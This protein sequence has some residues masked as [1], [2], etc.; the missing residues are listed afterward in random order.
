MR[1]ILFILVAVLLAGC[2]KPSPEPRTIRV[3]VIGGMVMSGMWAE[4]AAQF[5]H[6]TGL[7]LDVVATGPKEVIGP[8]FREGTA[9]VLTMHSSDVATELVA[10]G[11][12]RNLR[13]WARNELVILAPPGDPAGI[14]GWQDGAAALRR[15]AETQSRFIDAK[16]AGKRI[17]AE[18]L[19]KKSGVE[20]VGDWMLKDESTSPTDLLAYAER[21]SAYVLTGRIPV[22][23]GKLPNGGMRIAVHGDPDMQRPY[24]V[25]EADPA[26]IPSARSAAARALGDYLT[27]PRGQKFLREFASRQPDGIPLFYPLDRQP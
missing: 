4:L 9:D 1:T 16:G 7:H 26:K 11:F 25:L 2:G 18:K 21:M 13:P 24:V 20:P 6:D 19:W 5:E 15:I 10:S 23:F 22:L 3:A 8:A 27:G 17:I 12:A 14:I